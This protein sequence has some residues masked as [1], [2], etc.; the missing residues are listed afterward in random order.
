MFLIE[1]IFAMVDG[2]VCQQTVGISMVTKCT[3]LPSDLFLHSF[4]FRFSSF[5]YNFGVF[6]LMFWIE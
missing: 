3:P 6:K 1:N 4:L 5:D 2:C